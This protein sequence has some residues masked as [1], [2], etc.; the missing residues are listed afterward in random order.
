MLTVCVSSHDVC[1]NDGLRVDVAAT[2][3]KDKMAILRMDSGFHL[4][5]DLWLSAFISLLRILIYPMGLPEVLTAAR[6]SSQ[7]K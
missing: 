7:S 1:S 5:S 4:Y 3:T 2:D 6:L